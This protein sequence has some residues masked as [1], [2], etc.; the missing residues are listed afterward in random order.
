MVM[1][2]RSESEAQDSGHATDLAGIKKLRDVPLPT[3]HVIRQLKGLR[4]R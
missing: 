3:A 2:C 1:E 4:G